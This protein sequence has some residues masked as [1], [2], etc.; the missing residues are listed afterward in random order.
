MPDGQGQTGV[1]DLDGAERWEVLRG[2]L[3]VMYGNASGGVVQLLSDFSPGPLTLGAQLYAASHATSKLA[4]SLKGDAAGGVISANLSTFETEGWRRHSMAERTTANLRARFDTP[5]NGKLTLIYNH[6]DQPNTQDPLGLTA[7]QVAA[8]P[9]QAGNGAVTFNT[10]KSVSHRQLGAAWEVTPSSA[11]TLKAALYGGAREVEQFLAFSGS[12][13]TSSGGV[14]DLNRRFDGA[15][16]QATLSQGSA[17]LTA[18]LDYDT[19]SELRRG[20]VNSAGVARALR[21]D[22]DNTATNR[23]AWLLAD[24]TLSDAWQL[25][26][27]ARRADV[28][29]TISDHFINAQNPDDSGNT[30]FA[31]T[32][33]MLGLNWRFAHAQSVYVSAGQGFET[34]TLAEIAYRPDGQSGSNLALRAA[35]ARTTELG[36]KAVYSRGDIRAAV[37]TTD[38]RDEVVNGPAVQPGRNTFV[39]AA[40]TERRGAELSAAYAFMPQW[41]AA[42]SL[43]AIRARFASFTDAAGQNLSGKLLPGVPARSAWAELEYRV[44]PATRMALEW[45]HTGRVWANDA[46]T[47]SAPAYNLGALRT[48]HTWACAREQQACSVYA[49]IDN[50]TDKRTIGSVIVNANNRQYFEPAPGRTL[51]LGV[52]LRF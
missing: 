50:L 22:E 5:A 25:L 16:L 12:A 6:L 40:R 27:G 45:R 46:N 51:G 21:R 48:T 29:F 7:E 49:R 38:V 37:F 17:R 41:R 23:D 35:I 8:D 47:E 11:L 24:V 36:Y 43:T 44:T 31:H 39:N 34:P 10:R 18:G 33:R 26:A 4:L 30:R 52:N 9:R 1:F 14:I 28:R 3:A 15:A 13:P 32:N 20:F 2:P 42:V 19:Q